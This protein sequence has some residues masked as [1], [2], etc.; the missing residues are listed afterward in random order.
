MPVTRECLHVLSYIYKR[1]FAR[2]RCADLYPPRTAQIRPILT[3]PSQRRRISRLPP[4]GGDLYPVDNM[5][6]FGR[7]VLPPGLSCNA[8]ELHPSNCWGIYH[9]PTFKFIAGIFNF[10]IQPWQQL[11]N[12]LFTDTLTSETYTPQQPTWPT[13]NT[14]VAETARAVSSGA[15]NSS[16]S[17]ALSCLDP[18]LFYPTLKATM[19]SPQSGYIDVKQASY[20]GV[21]QVYTGD[22]QTGDSI[23]TQTSGCWQPTTITA[24]TCFGSCTTYYN[25]LL[26]YYG[27]S[28]P[29]LGLAAGDYVQVMRP[30]YV[31]P[32]AVQFHDAHPYTF[33]VPYRATV[34]SASTTN[35]LVFTLDVVQPN[36]TQGTTCQAITMQSA[37]YLFFSSTNTPIQLGAGTLTG[38][39]GTQC[40]WTDTSGTN[41]STYN[42]AAVNLFQTN[43]APDVNA[44]VVNASQV[45]AQASTTVASTTTGANTFIGQAAPSIFNVVWF[46]AGGTL[47]NGTYCYEAELFLISNTAIHTAPTAATCGTASNGQAH[48]RLVCSSL[49]PMHQRDGSSASSGVRLHRAVRSDLSATA[50]AKALTLEQQAP[51]SR[52]VPRY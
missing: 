22:A 23:W 25:Q 41:Y 20:V 52:P 45:T 46:S 24:P 40:T 2:L 28:A 1:Q 12:T 3:G 5:E 39:A 50:R 27:G 19:V 51:V 21:V 38:G 9:L 16:G 48:K 8:D 13:F 35:S 31:N 42:G 15:I 17:Y 33:S 26:I 44:S 18:L 6:Q 7:Q 11:N 34:N 49:A 29:S 14:Q 10:P 32:Y 43:R 4:H 30:K 47:S 36:G 37:D